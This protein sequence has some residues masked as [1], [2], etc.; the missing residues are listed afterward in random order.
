MS[1]LVKTPAAVQ[2]SLNGGDTGQ[3]GRQLCSVRRRQPCS[4]SRDVGQCGWLGIFIGPWD[5]LPIKVIRQF[6]G[7]VPKVGNL[8]SLPAGTFQKVVDHTGQDEPPRPLVM[9]AEIIIPESG[10]VGVSGNFGLRHIPAG[11]P[12]SFA[13]NLVYLFQSPRG[14]NEDRRMDPPLHRSQVGAIG[15]SPPCLRRDTQLFLNFGK[16]PVPGAIRPHFHPVRNRA[17]FVHLFPCP[18]NTT[19]YA[20]HDP[21]RPDDPFF[22]QGR[23]GHLDAGR[24]TSRARKK[25]VLPYPSNPWIS[26]M[27]RAPF[28]Q[29]F[30][31]GWS[32]P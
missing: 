24:I 20:D 18:A 23:E 6:Q 31:I 19:V 10:H 14:W 9:T 8:N 2:G 28:I 27:M 4:E 1:F 32:A 15:Q 17:H 7:S 26:G 12:V 3:G 25:P 30:R 16:V 22:D 5:S 21:L 29:Q 11:Y 13:P